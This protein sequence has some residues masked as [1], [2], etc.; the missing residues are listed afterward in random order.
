V[1]REEN[2]GHIYDEPRILT[3]GEQGLVVELGDRI[4]PRINGRVY[5]LAV[6]VADE[7]IDGVLEVVPTYR[8]LMIFFD[9][10]RIER[11]KLVARVGALAG[12]A[13][14]DSRKKSPAK[15]V[16]VPVCYGGEFGPD[17]D[18]VADCNRLTAE[19]VVRIHSERTYPVYMMG[20][21]P[22]F[23]YLGGMSGRIAAPRMEKPRLK[24]AA[25]S[26]GIAGEQTGIYPLESPGGWRIIGRTPLRLFSPASSRPFPIAA[27]NAVR[28][29]PVTEEEFRHLEM[30][31]ASDDQSAVEALSGAAGAATISVVKP[32]LL[33]TVQ[34]EGRFG[35][36]AFGMPVSGAMDRYAYRVANILAGNGF[37]AAALEMSLSGGVFRFASDAYVSVC[38]A[39]MGAKL[40]GV[41]VQNWSGFPVAAGSVLAFG[42]AAR[43]CRTYLAINGGIAVPSF[44][45]SRSTCLRAGIGGFGGRALKAGDVLPAG[46]AGTMP[47]KKRILPHHF[48]PRY[49]DSLTLRV[50]PGFQEILFTNEGIDVFYSAEYTVSPRN[51]RMGYLL[52][53]LQVRH[54]D[55]ADIVSDALCPGAVQVPG[56]GLPIIM[57]ADHQTTGGYAKIGAVIGP[58]LSALVQARQ[59]DRIR[60]VRCSDEEAVAA[61]LR[62]MEI[63]ERIRAQFPD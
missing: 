41:S 39:D 33:T 50:L 15:V 4:D 22:G 35:Y 60:F 45:G 58:D 62:E 36:R 18:Y 55:G 38:G 20:F 46:V 2:P 42:H 11:N 49:P 3:A 52:D 9:P 16:R 10:L 48:V 29:E 5:C 21:M 8:S 34:D 57:T 40:D 44:M 19:E 25:G 61:L 27:G 51:D 6:A 1:K 53:G 56:N 7:N 17:L 63:Y 37:S 14:E 13:D 47:W 12:V 24:V 32:G 26:V 59:G 23:P 28:F 31:N 54:A 30:K 43:G